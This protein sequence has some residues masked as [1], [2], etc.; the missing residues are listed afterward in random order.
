MRKGELGGEQVGGR[1][2]S[3]GPQ[4]DSCGKR[5]QGAAYAADMT[6]L[7]WGRNL[8]VA[9]SKPFLICYQHVCLPSMGP[10][11]DSCGKAGGGRKNRAAALPSMGPQLDSC[12]KAPPFMLA[13]AI[14]SSLQWGRN[15]IVAESEHPTVDRKKGDALQWGRNLIVAESIIPGRPGVSICIPSM[16]PQ[17]DS[18]GKPRRR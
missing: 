1:Q 4:L 2:P 13:G 18:C 8:I 17:L 11:L 15:L 16:G 6:D 9:E 3:M 12:G 5:G 14:P 7:Q 10:Q